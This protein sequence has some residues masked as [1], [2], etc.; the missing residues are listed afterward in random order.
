MAF[1]LN[2]DTAVSSGSFCLAR[3]GEV[4]HREL[5]EDPKGQGAWL[6]EAIKSVF[7]RNGLRLSALDAIAVSNGPGSYTGLRIGLATA[8]GL[9]YALNKPLI[10]LSTLHVMALSVKN[11]AKD[12]ICPMIDAR[13]MEV[14][15]ALFHKNLD[16]FEA[17]TA[18]VLS[19][20]SY[21]EV[22]QEHQVLFTGNGSPKFQQL[23]QH[24]NAQY[25]EKTVTAEQM[26]P[27]SETAFYAENFSDLAYC[28]PF[29]LKGVFIK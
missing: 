10:L 24:P 21:E 19:Q 11:D 28:E 9:C 13:R 3:D 17:P 25:L 22:L 12:L 26:A 6:H 8:K 23:L 27:L 2:I 4:L 1:I 5:S 7:D 18:R 20:N 16:I 14:F 29:Y 15:T